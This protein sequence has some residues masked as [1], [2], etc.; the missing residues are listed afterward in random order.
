MQLRGW[1]CVGSLR[2]TPGSKLIEA[3]AEWPTEDCWNTTLVLPLTFARC[4]QT[5]SLSWSLLGTS[6]FY[7]KRAGADGGRFCEI[8][9]EKR[10]DAKERRSAAPAYGE[11]DGRAAFGS[12]VL[13]RFD[14]LLG[15]HKKNESAV[16]MKLHIMSG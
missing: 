3:A 15:N 16:Y 4:Y 13:Q 12:L 5:A 9:R 1:C 7:P 14:Q 2:A 10:D 8:H 11:V 6:L